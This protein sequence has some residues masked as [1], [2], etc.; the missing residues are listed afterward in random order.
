MKVSVDFDDTLSRKY[1]QEYVSELIDKGVDVWVVTARYDE[2]HKYKFPSNPT[3]EDLWEVV[4]N[5]SI[6][7]WKVRF[8]CNERKYKYL[9]GS[10]FVFHLD[11]D[12][13]EIRLLNSYSHS[14]YSG[15]PVPI[16]LKGSWRNKCNRLLKLE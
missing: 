2:N 15:N 10:N 5:L 14:S 1:V 6:P 8:Q 9:K 16:L 3:I 7:R 4:D 12:E 11:N 13:D